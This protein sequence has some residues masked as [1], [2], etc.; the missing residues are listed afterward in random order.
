MDAGGRETLPL[1]GCE[2]DAEELR[3]KRRVLAVLTGRILTIEGDTVDTSLM[4]NKQCSSIVRCSC[5]LS[6]KCC[7]CGDHAKTHN[8][9]AF[10]CT[11][12][13]AFFRRTALSEKSFRCVRSG[14]CKLTPKWRR[15]QKCRLDKCYRMG[16]KKEWIDC[17][18]RGWKRGKSGVQKEADDE[19]RFRQRSATDSS[20]S[21]STSRTQ[22]GRKSTPEESATLGHR[23]GSAET[24]SG[25][26][27]LMMQPHHSKQSI[28]KPVISEPPR[29]PIAVMNPEAPFRAHSVIVSPAAKTTGPVPE[30]MMPTGN[31]VGPSV[32][33]VVAA[34]PLTSWPGLA[35]NLATVL[36]SPADEEITLKVEDFR[37]LL[38]AAIGQ[39]DLKRPSLNSENSHGKIRSTLGDTDYTDLSACFESTPSVPT[40]TL[41]PELMRHHQ[42]FEDKIY[43]ALMAPH[44]DIQSPNSAFEAYVPPA[45]DMR[46]NPVEQR[47]IEILREAFKEL[48]SIVDDRRR[49]SMLM[50]QEHN[51]ADILNIMDITMRRLVNVARKLPAFNDL[52]QM[53]KVALLRDGMIKLLMLHGVRRYCDET[54]SFQTPV[55]PG[56]NAHVSIQMFEGLNK[57]VNQL[58]KYGFLFLCE[59]VHR[60]VRRDNT[61]ISLMMVITLFSPNMSNIENEADARTIKKHQQEYIF[62]TYQYLR[63]IHGVFASEIFN[64]VPKAL[65]AINNNEGTSRDLFKNALRPDEAE[66]LPQEFYKISVAE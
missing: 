1:T 54:K 18:R 55:I 33:Q 46:L 38:E 51:P 13:K 3:L 28:D 23:S 29:E 14:R 62:L 25:D 64:S 56:G 35:P 63:S 8:F 19:K 17:R 26:D 59:T 12:C 37:R 7:V 4:A 9:G 30:Q 31:G 50:K 21:S 65:K 47:E 6:K 40:R 36:S 41:P 57:Q 52:S 61:A 66:S 60:E 42:Q 11:S 20:S 58:S 53:G 16:M 22:T 5:Q 44:D 45:D 24:P 15:C 48:D 2:E 32:G 27:R 34:S 39:L 10:T 43:E 49:I